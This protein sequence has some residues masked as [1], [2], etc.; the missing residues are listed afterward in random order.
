MASKKLNKLEGTRV[1]ATAA[2][3][4]VR[5][6]AR[7]TKRSAPKAR[8]AK[9]KSSSTKPRRKAEPRRKPQRR[10]PGTRRR[11][12]SIRHVEKFPDALG[13]VRTQRLGRRQQFPDGR[14][15]PLLVPITVDHDDDGAFASGDADFECAVDLPATGG[16]QED[17]HGVIVRDGVAPL[18]RPVGQFDRPLQ[19]LAIHDVPGVERL[20]GTPVFVANRSE[21]RDERVHVLDRRPA[22]DHLH[23]KSPRLD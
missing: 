22:L 19:T 6:A 10:Q 20:D 21:S 4:A 1:A 2:R 3:P 23:Q 17:L 14:R 7:V 13:V 5:G 11:E 16:V 9:R 8:K 12:F 18:A 15:R